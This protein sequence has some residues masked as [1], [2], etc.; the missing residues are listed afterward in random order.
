MLATT[1]N[2]L[3]QNKRLFLITAICIALATHFWAGSRVPSLNDKASLGGALI[4]E[5]PL[6]FEAAYPVDPGDPVLDKIYYTTVNWVLTNRR[7]M[8]FGI[9]IAAGFMT[10]LTLLKRRSFSSHFGNTLLGLFIG[11]PLGVCVNCA[12]PIARGLHESGTRLETTLV[13]MISSPTLNIIVLT[14]LFSLMPI[15]MAITKVAMTLFFLLVLVP[16][17]A[18]YVFND[19][20]VTQNISLPDKSPFSDNDSFCEIPSAEPDWFKSIIWVA[21][22]YVSNLFY[23]IKLTLPL[24][25]LAGLMGA[26][27]ITLF[28]WQQMTEMFVDNQW[29]LVALGVILIAAIGLFLPVPIAFDVAIVSA[30]LASGVPVIYAMTLLFTLGIFSV[31]SFFIVWTGISKKVAIVLSGILLLMGILSG[32][33]VDQYTKWD[34]AN[35]QKLFKEFDLGI[36]SSSIGRFFIHD[37]AASTLPDVTTP[38]RTKTFQSNNSTLHV[39]EIKMQ[40][41]SPKADKLFTRHYGEEFGL[42]SESSAFL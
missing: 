10:L 31:Y 27:A 41:P 16:L 32:I 17:L 18:R 20:L 28:P 3:Q 35:Q 5:D 19:E 26:I 4:L 11:M 38:T 25:L 29:Y 39:T 12:A 24:M 23:I 1:P 14:M 42:V 21:K 13:T 2:W 36:D 30:L 22:K 9:L 15:Y 7:G 37:A 33:V 34:D 6:G 8:T 40:E